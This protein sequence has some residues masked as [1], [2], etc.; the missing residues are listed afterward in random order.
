MQYRMGKRNIGGALFLCHWPKSLMELGAWLSS[1]E[2]LEYKFWIALKMKS[3]FPIKGRIHPAHYGLLYYVKK[4]AQPT[5]N[6]VRHRSP[7]CRNKNAASLSGTTA[8]TEGSTNNSKQTETFGFKSATFG[9]TQDQRART[10]S[11]RTASMNF[12]CKFRAC[13]SHGEQS[14]RLVLDC[15]SGGGSTLHAAQLHNRPRIGIDIENSDASLRR[16]K[17]FFD[18]QETRIPPAR[19][20]RCF[21]KNFVERFLTVHPNSKQRPFVRVRRLARAI[22]DKFKSKSRVYPTS[23][24][25]NGATPD[26]NSASRATLRRTATARRANALLLLA[27][28]FDSQIAQLAGIDFS[29]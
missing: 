10:R 13:H 19:I 27:G 11:E 26:R 8:D 1:L 12:Q 21:E 7:R 29:G 20:R 9:R 6:V 17:T 24:A 18:G 23:P 16:L 3:G 14:G 22:G 25:I 4:G 15:F 5:F 2:T 28:R